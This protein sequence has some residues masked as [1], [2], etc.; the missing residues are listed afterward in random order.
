MTQREFLPADAP[1][2]S[3]AIFQSRK[4]AFPE[5][6]SMKLPVAYADMGV[7][8]EKPQFR[9]YSSNALKQSR[10]HLQSNQMHPFL[11]TSQ[12]LARFL[13]T[14]S[15][16]LSPAEIFQSSSKKSQYP[17]Y[18]PIATPGLESD[19]PYTT[20]KKGI[21][22]D[23]GKRLPSVLKKA[24][25]LPPEDIRSVP[26][27]RTKRTESPPVVSIGMTDL[28]GIP[29]PW[30]QAV[31]IEQASDCRVR[32]DKPVTSLA[33][34]VRETMRQDFDSLED[35]IQQAF[36]GVSSPVPQVLFST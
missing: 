36:S 19:Q 27:I 30:T 14:P 33:D 13:S 4:F 16:H 24:L 8:S 10:N 26:H 11:P 34:E 3:S 6:S 35:F 9:L 17:E 20:M 2:V 7:L 28:R 25:P 23:T 18:S 31:D 22:D 1:F 12:T 21:L 5:L 15:E 29:T 32:M